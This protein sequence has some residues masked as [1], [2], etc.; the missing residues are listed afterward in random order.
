MTFGPNTIPTGKD[1]CAL[2]CFWDLNYEFNAHTHTGNILSA[3]DF[4]L[5]AHTAGIHLVT[6]ANTHT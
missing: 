4:E 6:D 1:T 2:F 3:I 5:D